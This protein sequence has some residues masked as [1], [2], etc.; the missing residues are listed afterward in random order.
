MKSNDDMAILQHVFSAAFYSLIT[1]GFANQSFTV[2]FTFMVQVFRQCTESEAH[3]KNG[4]DN[5]RSDWKPRLLRQFLQT[6]DMFEKF[7]RLIRFRWLQ[8]FPAIPGRTCPLGKLFWND[9]PKASSGFDGSGRYAMGWL[10]GYWV[11]I[12]VWQWM[13]IPIQGYNWGN[14]FLFRLTDYGVSSVP[15]SRALDSATM[16][17]LAA[18]RKCGCPFLCQPSHS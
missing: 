4:V 3:E 18:G 14:S 17:C 10:T 9:C 7:D 8:R 2:L 5:R 6:Q 1:S 13:T 12:C 11:T 15:L 16:R